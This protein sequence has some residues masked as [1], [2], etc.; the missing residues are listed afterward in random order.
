MTQRFTGWRKSTYT[1][2]NGNCVEV[3]VSG[4]RAV[5]IRDSKGDSDVVVELTP[6][7]W[8]ALLSA[9]RSPSA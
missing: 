4:E 9:L 7:Q 5:G 3:A 1:D 6:R 2:P 8:S